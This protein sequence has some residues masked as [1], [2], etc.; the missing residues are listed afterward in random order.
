MLIKRK[1]FENARTEI[2]KLQEYIISHANP[3][4]HNPYTPKVY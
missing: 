4:I 1:N 3:V 2:N